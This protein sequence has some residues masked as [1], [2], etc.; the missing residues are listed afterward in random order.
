MPSS[1]FH[2]AHG[3]TNSVKEKPVELMVILGVFVLWFCL[4]RWILP[5]M[6]VQT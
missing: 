6:G 2:E 1:L 3:D 4:N 5:A